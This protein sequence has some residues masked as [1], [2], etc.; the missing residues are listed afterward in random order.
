MML[1]QGVGLRY[2]HPP[3]R[4]PSPSFEVPTMKFMPTPGLRPLAPN[5]PGLRPPTARP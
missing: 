3:I 2:K 5:Q 4:G 1:M